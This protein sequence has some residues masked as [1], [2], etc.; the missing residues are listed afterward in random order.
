MGVFDFEEL[1]ADMLGITDDQRDEDDDL[2]EREFCDKFDM[3]LE[4]GYKLARHLLPH[5]PIVEA[6]LTGERYHAFVSKTGP[7]ILMKCGA[8]QNA[9]Q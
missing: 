4:H 3:D 2:L 7:F 9:P 8:K 5:T 6:G 1:V